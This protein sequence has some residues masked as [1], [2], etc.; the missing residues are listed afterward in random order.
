MYI[1]SFKN[2]NLSVY[3]TSRVSFFYHPPP[4]YILVH[5]YVYCI[6]KN[7]D[8]NLKWYLQE[9]VVRVETMAAPPRLDQWELSLQAR[10]L[11]TNPRSGIIMHS[12]IQTVFVLT[13]DKAAD[14]VI[15][16][17]RSVYFASYVYK[18]E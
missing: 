11:K 13:T 18:N 7:N 15:M 12:G 6:R 2:G 16:Y 17:E 8:K 1:F 14:P 10:N 5:I 4:H 9:N 3:S